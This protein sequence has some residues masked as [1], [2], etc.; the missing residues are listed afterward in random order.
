MFEDEKAKEAFDKQIEALEAQG[1]DLSQIQ[2]PNF[3]L[4]NCKIKRI[5]KQGKIKIESV[6]PE[7][8]LIDRQQNPLT[9]LSSFRTKC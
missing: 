4:Y 1:L 6:P 5:K 2:K 3:N 8:F 9:M 7:E